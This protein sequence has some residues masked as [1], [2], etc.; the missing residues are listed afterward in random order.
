M[1]WLEKSQGLG[2]GVS[3]RD[4]EVGSLRAGIHKNK[5]TLLLLFGGDIEQALGRPSGASRGI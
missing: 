5:T 3:G 1:T 2:L 4:S